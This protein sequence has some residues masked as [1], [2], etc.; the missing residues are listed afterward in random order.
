MAYM[1]LWCVTIQITKCPLQGR[2]ELFITV[3]FVFSVCALL[4]PSLFTWVYYEDGLLLEGRV[5]ARGEEDV[6][7][8]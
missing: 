4:G 8:R 5:C 6:K 2:T 1:Y 7:T 3:L